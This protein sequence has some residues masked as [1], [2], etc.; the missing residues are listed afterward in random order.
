[1]LPDVWDDNNTGRPNKVAAMAFKSMS[2]LYDAS[3]LMQNDL[4]SV[5]IKGYDKERLKVAAQSATAVLD[6]IKTHPQTT[7]TG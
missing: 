7:K 4:S 6:Y 1:M 3:P 5:Q 2:Q